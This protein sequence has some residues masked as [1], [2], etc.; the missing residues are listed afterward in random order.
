[1]LALI[2]LCSIIGLSYTVWKFIGNKTHLITLRTKCLKYTIES[3]AQKN[4]LDKMLPHQ[5]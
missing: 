4:H 1:M 5:R 3:V 2:A